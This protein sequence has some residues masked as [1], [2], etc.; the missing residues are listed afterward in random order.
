MEDM[1]NVY[2]ILVGKHKGKRLF[3][4]LRHRWEVNIEMDLGGI[5]FHGYALH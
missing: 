3:R 2:K 4:R 5:R 1:R